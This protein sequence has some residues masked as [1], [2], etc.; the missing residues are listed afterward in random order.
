MS[1]IK[2]CLF[3][4]CLI[5]L[6]PQPTECATETI[7]ATLTNET[8]SNFYKTPVL[9]STDKWKLVLTWS[10]AAVLSPTTPIV[11]Q[12]VNGVESSYTLSGTSSGTGYYIIE[13]TS[14]I[15]GYLVLTLDYDIFVTVSSQLF[16][17]GVLVKSSTGVYY[18]NK[19]VP[20]NQI[21]IASACRLKI[22][23]NGITPTPKIG[24]YLTTVG[25]SSPDFQ[26][27]TG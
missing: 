20:I 4:I 26:S 23:I 14:G 3:A 13:M 7:F 24:V 1:K 11:K 10:G 12:W 9:T 19:H 17:N 15:N 2:I 16:I 22:K 18:G 8:P 27:S 6:I 25:A 21:A 5:G